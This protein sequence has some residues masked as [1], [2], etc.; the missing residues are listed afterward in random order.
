MGLFWSSSKPIVSETEFKERVLVFLSSHD[1]SN[2]DREKAKMV[3][4]GHLY[5]SG[6]QAGI[7]KEE[8]RQGIK[9][10]K[11]TTDISLERLTDLEEF[12]LSLAK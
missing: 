1:W 5:E 10:L 11:K 8:I 3:F 6:S 12:M 2:N 4:E 9:L 7:D